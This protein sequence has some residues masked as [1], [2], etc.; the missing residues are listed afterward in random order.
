LISDKALEAAELEDTLT[1]ER[2]T[3]QTSA[4]FSMIGAKACTECLPPE[5]EHDE[6]GNYWPTAHLATIVLC[7]NLRWI[8]IGSGASSNR[9]ELLEPQRLR[10]RLEASKR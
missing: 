6:K 10:K 7:T 5:I 1:H 3:V 2:C 8:F 4:I 9:V